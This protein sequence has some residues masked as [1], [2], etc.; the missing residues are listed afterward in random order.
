[1]GGIFAFCAKPSEAVAKLLQE[2]ANQVALAI[3]NMKSY[4]EIAALRV[5]LEKENLYLQESKE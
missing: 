4:E 1:V 2:V 3:A 5:R